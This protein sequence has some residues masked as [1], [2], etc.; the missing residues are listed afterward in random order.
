MP[1]VH[2]LQHRLSVRLPEAPH[3]GV[4]EAVVATQI[5]PQVTAQRDRVGRDVH[6]A[7]ELGVKAPRE[8]SSV[9]DVVL[10]SGLLGRL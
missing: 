8:R 2:Q 7:G 4:G 6:A 5:Q 3:L 1:L 10:L 9:R